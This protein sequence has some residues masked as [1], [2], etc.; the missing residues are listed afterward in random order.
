MIQTVSNNVA[1]DYKAIE[2]IVMRASVSYDLHELS[3]S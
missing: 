1:Y 3:P 2:S